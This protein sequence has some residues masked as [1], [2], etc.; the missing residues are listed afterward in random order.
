MNRGCSHS[1]FPTHHLRANTFRGRSFRGRGRGR[2]RG[3]TLIEL[4]ACLI[5]VG[6]LATA[7]AVSLGGVRQLH[8]MEDVV[9]QLA[10][11]DRLTREHAERF[12]EA[13]T[14]LFDLE[15][16]QVQ[17]LDGEGRV[18]ADR[19]AAWPLPA[20]FVFR[21]VRV[22]SEDWST[23]QV[24][25]AFSAMGTSPTYAIHLVRPSTSTETWLIFTG[26]SGQV[27][28]VESQEVVDAIFDAI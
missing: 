13:E 4:T 7:A 15:A 24:S 22:Q 28:R 27:E 14:L 3:F 17:R 9:D 23:R 8:E 25:V 26:A 18:D 20:G 12:D 5:I 16:G 11:I 2:G 1:H 6:L 19:A 10:L 21:G